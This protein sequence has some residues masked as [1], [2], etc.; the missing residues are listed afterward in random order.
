MRNLY[1]II[2]RRAQ[3]FPDAVALG[4]QVG[5]TWR[6]LTS[7]HLLAAVDA[8]AHQLATQHGVTAGDRV[9]LWLPNHL[10]TPLYFFACW[11]LGALAVPFDR[12]MNPEAAARIIA[13]TAPRLLVA[14]YGERPVWSAGAPVVEWS[15]AEA[16][17]APPPADWTPPAEPL[18]ALFYTSGTTGAPKGCMISHANLLSQVEVLPAKIPLGPDCRLA[19]IL[20]LSHLFELTAG[21]LYPLSQ[22]AAIHY[23]PSR[24]GPDI[25]RVLKEQRITHMVVVPQV[26]QL[27]GATLHEQLE[28]Q[29]PPRLYHALLA[30]AARLPLAARRRLFWPVHRKIGG[31]LRLMGAGGAALPVEVQRRWEI[32]GV[33]VVQGYGTSE[34]SPIIACGV[35][36]GST[37]PGTCGT[38]LANVH[39][40][41]S[42]AGEILVQGP[43]VMAGYWQD[44]AQTAEVLKDG[45]YH[46]GDL[47][48]ID[49]LGNLTIAGRAKELL[50]LPSGMN[51]WPHDV[52]EVLRAQPGVKDAAVVLA[53][54]PGG[55]ATL[56]AY[57]IPSGAP[58][59]I[60]PILAAANKRLA[61]HQRVATAA[62]WPE[63][64]FP[65][66]HTLKVKRR[67]LPPPGAPG[68]A[69]AVT[70]TAADQDAVLSAIAGVARVARVQ[71]EQTLGELGL[72][73]LT[74]V[75]LALALEAKT[76]L[77]LEDGELTAELTVAAVHELVLA[78]GG[79]IT[80]T[81][82]A[83]TPRAVR[84]AGLPP[85]WLY[86][87]LGRS[88]GVLGLP[89][90]LLARYGVTELRVEGGEHLAGLPARVILA[91]THHSFA[92]F[93][94]VKAALARTPARRL[95]GRMI[96]AAAA[97]GVAGAGL[98]GWY[99]TLAF[100]LYPIRQY[101]ER[102][103]S[104]RRLAELAARGNPVLIF[105]QGR[106]V[107]RADEVAGR[108]A[109]DFKAGVGH[110][111][112]ALDAAVV[113]FGIAGTERLVPAHV[114]GHRGLVL[115]GIPVKL[116]RGPA[117]LV[118][119]APARPQ[120][121]ES[122]QAFTSR[123]QAL[124]FALT[125]RAYALLSAEPLTDRGGRV[126]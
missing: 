60:A 54:Q 12:E 49:A 38:P 97:V 51:V 107:E 64:D 40:R 4:S 72:D 116:T 102:E 110:L 68:A 78:R 27:M 52:E 112:D 37:P 23:I 81:G 115:G 75:E 13:A 19:S 29:L 7:R 71:P 47:G 95:A 25:V 58:A 70:A 124:C 93:P 118:F 57:L 63:A 30:L 73:S 80:D 119:G 56:H 46:T 15:E 125:D 69:E 79:S 26:L 90:D 67:L 48:T 44:P 61:V 96:V 3:Q 77:H 32:I 39:V 22:G 42:D 9:V 36:D 14:G 109:A 6:A 62:W 33:R 87:R 34:T 59:A 105:P 5:L 106:H 2:Q 45:W 66:T 126:D 122:A 76:G 43:N 17:P 101:R 88:L 103:A 99:A 8:L 98:L 31:R 1:E 16:L 18:A 120:P 121:G 123:L 20:P 74:L 100:R 89:F 117:A 104:L 53:P 50:V 85:A 94:I 11:K 113:P 83:T 24:R 65:R 92:D 84:E 28:K 114:E 108:P 21:L 35:A 10:R 111:A 82:T 55:G 41:L 91:G 86:G